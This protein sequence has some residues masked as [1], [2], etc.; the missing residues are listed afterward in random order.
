MLFGKNETSLIPLLHDNRGH[1]CVSMA[2]PCV[3]VWNSVLWGQ[4]LGP[5]E[6]EPPF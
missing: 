3:H 6:A 1:I 5:D 4:E 2:Q